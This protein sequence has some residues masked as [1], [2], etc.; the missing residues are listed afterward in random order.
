MQRFALHC[1]IKVET[2]KITNESQPKLEGI[3]SILYQE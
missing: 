2:A 1:I 3:G